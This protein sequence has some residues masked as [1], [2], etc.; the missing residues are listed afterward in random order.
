MLL[1]L[2]S[3]TLNLFNS[4][5]IVIMALMIVGLGGRYTKHDYNNG[6]IVPSN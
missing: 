6:P 2:S 4:K 1:T 5:I 3:H